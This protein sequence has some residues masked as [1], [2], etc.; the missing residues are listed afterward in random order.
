MLADAAAHSL[1]VTAEDGIRHG[2]A[3][4]FI[5]DALASD[6]RDTGPVPVLVLGAP[7]EY[8][9][10]GN[11]PVILAQLGLDGPGIAASVVTALGVAEVVGG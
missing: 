1:V 6:S 9:V 7:D 3:G 11:P 5:A 4:S 8:I 10:Q 2:G